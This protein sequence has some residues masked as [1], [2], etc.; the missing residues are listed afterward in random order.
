MNQDFWKSPYGPV[1]LYIGGEGGLTSLTVQRGS[2]CLCNFDSNI[3]VKI[4]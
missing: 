4:S 1:F 3:L 2:S